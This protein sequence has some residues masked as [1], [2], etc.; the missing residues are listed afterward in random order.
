MVIFI[1]WSGDISKEIAEILKE[2][3]STLFTGVSDLSIFVSSEDIASGTEWFQEISSAINDSICGILCLTKE[4][5][6]SENVADWIEFEAGA[7]AYHLK[8]SPKTVIPFLFDV[9]I[10]NRS[11]LK[12]FEFIKF[13]LKQYT[14]LIT[15]LNDK[16]FGGI[17]D[18]NQVK[19]LAKVSYN[20]RLVP[21]VKKK[22]G[23]FSD[24]DKIEIFPSGD[25]RIIS[26]SIY[27]SCPMASIKNDDEYKTI[28]SLAL[29]AIKTLKDHCGVNEIYAPIEHIEDKSHF[30]GQEKAA[31]DN[32]E[33]LKTSEFLLCLY[34][35]PIPTSVLVEIGYG[36]ALNKKIIIFTLKK[37][38]S[39]LPYILQDGE[40]S[41]KN[42][43][44]YEYTTE[45]EIIQ[46][47]RKNG[48]TFLR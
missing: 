42:I 30:D 17:L 28:R 43:K 7:L 1:S 45:D 4:N 27:L 24:S 11:P 8:D 5:T 12:Q 22:L 44:I 21:E 15:D 9:T 6:T 35:K 31:V 48:K 41:F 38:K 26:G 33:K 34:P 10:P 16:H 40:K 25:S 47:I 23:E 36:I 2:E 20:E 18:K 29:N 19:D 37:N 14:K 46:K 3:L 32:F 39:K 13:D